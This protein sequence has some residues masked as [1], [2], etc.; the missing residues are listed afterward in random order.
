MQLLVSRGNA[1]NV[2]AKHYGNTPLHTAALKGH[3]AAVQ[4]LLEGNANVNAQDAYRKNTPL[5]NAAL[6]GH[7]DIVR[8]LLENKGDLFISTKGGALPLHKA[9][10]K[11]HG[12]VVACLLRH[13]ADS[14]ARDNDGYT[15]LHRAAAMGQQNVVDVLLATPPS[16]HTRNADW[17]T[18]LINARNHQ[19]Q[20]AAQVALEKGFTTVSQRIDQTLREAILLADGAVELQEGKLHLCGFAKVGK[21]TLVERVL[22]QDRLARIWGIFTSLWDGRKGEPLRTAGM[23]VSRLRIGKWVTNS[24]I[25]QSA[26][27]AFYGPLCIPLRYRWGQNVTHCGVRM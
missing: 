8:L 20:T 18:Q 11:G 19:G 27:S 2:A 5:H 17:I 7:L 13:N 16:R 12:A 14:M 15:G 9:A 21:T 4:I 22:S 3:V 10:H 26:M 23:N 6:N 25:P 1:V 24:S